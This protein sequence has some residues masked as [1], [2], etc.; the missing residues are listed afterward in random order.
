VDFVAN[1]TENMT[2]KKFE[3]RSTFFKLM[4]E[5]IVAQFLSRH[6]VVDFSLFM[7][8]TTTTTTTVMILIDQSN[9]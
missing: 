6:G 2:V 5:S 1:F 4:N 8:T 9:Q 7:T 3:N